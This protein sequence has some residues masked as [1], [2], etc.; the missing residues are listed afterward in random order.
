MQNETILF[1][2]CNHVTNRPCWWYGTKEYL[3]SAIVGPSQR[4]RASLSG[5]SQEIGCHV[6]ASQELGIL[7][8]DHCICNRIESGCMRMFFRAL[9]WF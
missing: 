7:C 2:T 5:M 9:H 1:L 4:G 6:V 3:I 8:G